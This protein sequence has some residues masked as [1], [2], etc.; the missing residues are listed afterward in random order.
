MKDIKDRILLSASLI[1]AM[2]D[3]TTVAVPMIF[4]LLYGSKHII[5]AYAQIGILSNLGLLATL[6]AQVL[7][8]NIAHRFEYRNILLVSSLGLAAALFLST[9]SVSFA[10]L[11][12]SFVMLRIFTS[13]YHPLFVAWI[14]ETQPPDGLGRAMGIQS[15]SGNVGVLLAFLSVGFLSQTFGWKVSLYFWTALVLVLTSAGYLLLRNVS[16]ASRAVPTLG[17]GSWLAI[18]G[19]IRH[20]IPG[21]F[22]GGLGWSVTIF[23]A[24]SLLNHEF[25]VPIGRTGLYLSLWIALGTI[26]GYAYGFISRLLGRKAVFLMS[27]GGAA[28]SLAV[29]GLAPTRPAVI[30]GILGFGVFL[31]MTYP[32]LHTFVGSTVAAAEQ[33]QAFSWASN[34]QMI[35]GAVISLLAG[36]LSD[37]MGI[38]TPFI[39][40]S[41]LA[42][43]CFV[44]YAWPRKK[45]PS[46]A[47]IA[48]PIPS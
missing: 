16:S 33:T 27:I 20:Y 10:V 13:V 11:L 43:A 15:G 46:P 6:A 23:Y 25:G 4:P 17:L 12:M 18:L 8:V 38:R 48:S 34:L 19:K 1:H 44:F 21:F 9:M 42:A 32:S 40:S 35:S 29:I 22:F 30:A 5:T 14:S 2:T 36:L 24:P 26:S 31:L 37:A 47:A 3:A 28:V 7:V 45:R 41:V 39:L